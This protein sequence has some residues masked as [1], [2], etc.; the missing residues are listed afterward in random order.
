LTF[1]NRKLGLQKDKPSSLIPKEARDVV[2]FKSSDFGSATD[3]TYLPF[4]NGFLS[5]TSKGTHERVSEH[6]GHGWRR[7]SCSSS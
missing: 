5:Q 3:V 2:E 7:V 4:S 1:P 6:I